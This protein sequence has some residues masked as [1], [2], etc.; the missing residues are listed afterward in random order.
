MKKETKKELKNYLLILGLSLGMGI[1]VLI[2]SSWREF[3]MYD[4]FAAIVMLMT[5]IHLSENK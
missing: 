1:F 4:M 5:Y 3:S 2:I